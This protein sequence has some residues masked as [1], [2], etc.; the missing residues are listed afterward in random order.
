MNPGY[1][2]VNLCNLFFAAE[3]IKKVSIFISKQTLQEVTRNS[4]IQNGLI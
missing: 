4:Q 3:D 2:A 1:T